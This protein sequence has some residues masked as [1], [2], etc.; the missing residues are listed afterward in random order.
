MADQLHD[1]H[2]IPAYVYTPLQKEHDEIRILVLEPAWDHGSPIH[3]SFEVLNSSQRSSYEALSYTWGDLSLTSRVLVDQV[4]Q[5]P[6]TQNLDQVL[7]RL[8]Q[9][10]EKRRLWIDA[11]CIN[12]SDDKEKSSQIPQMH[13]I[14]H[15]ASNV[16]AWLGA[17]GEAET[18]GMRLLQQL[19]R[20]PRAKVEEIE[21]QKGHHHFSYSQEANIAALLSLP[22]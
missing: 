18:V 20:W 2:D 19:S 11:L 17:G 5:L 8:R 10:A 15:D 9:K 16:V 1:S 14:Y 3:V 13:S 22:W 12:Q 4:H 6:I 7:R 21:T